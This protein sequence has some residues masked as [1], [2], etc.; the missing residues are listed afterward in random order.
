MTQPG[1]K[2]L[3]ALLLAAG[4]SRRMGDSNKLTLPVAGVPLLRRCAAT[5][6]G[7]RLVELVVVVGHEQEV[8]RQL[9]QG[10]PARIVYNENYRAGQMTSVAC[11]LEA[12]QKPCAGIMICLSDQPLLDTNDFRIIA[13]GFASCPTSIMV[14]VYKGQRGNPVVLDYQHREAILAGQKNLGC[15][16]LIENNPELVTTLEMPN[17]HVTIDLDTPGAY[18][19]VEQRLA[20]RGDARANITVNG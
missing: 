1:K 18:A 14:P 3:S 12:L 20:N 17:D 16:R 6:A 5:L 15:R 8:A 13:E 2:I 19:A 10:F 7:S 11:G 4:E 9:L